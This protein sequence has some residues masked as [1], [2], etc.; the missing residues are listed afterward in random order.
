MCKGWSI[1]TKSPVLWKKVNIEFSPSHESQTFVVES[2]VNTLPP[3]VTAITLDFTYSDDW[4]KPLNFEQLSV[5][6]QEKCP[7]VKMLS[8]K[9]AVL[10]DTLPLII[11]FCSLFLQK[12]EVL[13]L[14]YS[15]FP[16]NPAKRV[17]S[18]SSKIEI[19]DVSCCHLGYF[20]KPPFLR[21]PNLKQLHLS[22][23]NVNDS[24][25]ENDSSFLNQLQVLDLGST[26]IKSGTFQA[27]QNH[28][29][30]L[31]ELY[32]CYAD[33]DELNFRHSV[34][35]HLTTICLRGCDVTCE[36]IVSLLQ[37]CQSLQNIYIRQY[38]AQ[39]YA[40]HPFVSFNEFKLEIVKV[41]SCSDH[42]V[43]NYL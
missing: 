8:L 40:R 1:L 35:P 32:L 13:V 25:F 39:S 7:H 37:S 16:D 18:S 19:L 22:Y 23:T 9:Y 10:S 2:F 33:L 30:Q 28:A 36:G 20:N 42:R 38:V 27:I 11:D 12:I 4:A 5:K 15:L 14:H 21:M 29:L 6:L 26:K 31:R 43:K 17:V 24:W 34:F 41:N 3:C